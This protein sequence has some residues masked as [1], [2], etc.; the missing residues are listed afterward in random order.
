MTTIEAEETEAEDL[1]VLEAL[2][3]E[4]CIKQSVLN[5]V[6]NVKFLSSLIQVG[7]FT[8]ENAGQRNDPKEDDIKLL[9]LNN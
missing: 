7:Q 1:I 2:D 4:R 8:A 6:R 9:T 3:L 5:V